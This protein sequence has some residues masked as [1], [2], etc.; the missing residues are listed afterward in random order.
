MKDEQI[1][2]ARRD[3]LKGSRLVRLMAF[4]EVEVAFHVH[5]DAGPSKRRLPRGSHG[6]STSSTFALYII[7]PQEMTKRAWEAVE[8]LEDEHRKIV[9]GYERK[10]KREAKTKP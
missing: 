1:E 9:E 3:R 5:R 2:Q 7:R 6:R 10:R 8:V 4:G